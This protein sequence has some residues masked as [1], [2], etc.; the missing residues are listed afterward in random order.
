MQAKAEL[1]RIGINPWVVDDKDERLETQIRQVVLKWDRS[2]LRIRQR[3]EE[4]SWFP[5][6]G[7]A[8]G[9][10]VADSTFKYI[11]RPLY[12]AGSQ[13]KSKNKRKEY[14]AYG[15]RHVARKLP[16][17]GKRAANVRRIE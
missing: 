7:E 1:M 10:T 17:E 12:E 4:K 3:E 6:G 8:A 13:N 2:R 9:Q 16:G 14:S 5:M 11:T 15:T